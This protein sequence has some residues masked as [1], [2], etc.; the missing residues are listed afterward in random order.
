M[1]QQGWYLY[2]R[3]WSLGIYVDLQNVTFSKID[4]P[5][6]WLSTGNVVNPDAPSAD[7][8]YELEM[9]ELV[10][11]TIIPSIGITAEF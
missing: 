11:G 3:K 8:R 10:S 2:F 5:V 7:Q 9:L 6:T 1:Y 4:Q